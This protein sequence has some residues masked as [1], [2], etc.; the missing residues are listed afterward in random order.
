MTGSPF[1]NYFYY[2]PTI[3]LNVL[4]DVEPGPAEANTLAIGLG[5]GLTVAAL[6]I[7]AVVLAVVYKPLRARIFPFMDAKRPEQSVPMSS[8]ASTPATHDSHGWQKSRTP[9]NQNM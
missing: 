1:A 9:T 8:G 6:V 4:F 3:T 5:V 2:D 7:G